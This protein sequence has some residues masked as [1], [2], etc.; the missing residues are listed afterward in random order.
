MS[1]VSILLT[2]SFQCHPTYEA[3]PVTY[4]ITCI[5]IIRETIYERN[6]LRACR[7]DV[8]SLENILPLHL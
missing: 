6:I 8:V 4:S 3:F 5:N 2:T 7:K 1:L